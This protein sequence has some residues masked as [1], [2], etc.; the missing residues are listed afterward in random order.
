MMQAGAPMVHGYEVLDVL[1]Q[2]GFGIVYRARQ[3]A[4]G[5]QVALKVDNRVL[6]SERDQRR[7]MREVTAA[8]ALSGHPNVAD[9]YDAGMLSDG[10]P[11]MVLELCPGGSLADR[12]RKERTLPPGEV[13]DI[14]VKIADALA[15]AHAAGVLHRDVKPA[16]ILI[17]SYGMVALSDF[18]LA[19]MP[20]GG[21]AQGGEVSVTR[22][23]L[24]PAY[25]P[26]EAFDLSEPT[27]AGDVY[28]LA[29]TLYAL[30]SGRPPRFPE[31]GVVHIAAIM[32]L[33]RQPIPDIPGVPPALTE[34]LRRAMATDPAARTPSAA[35]LRD[36]LAALPPAAFSA[37][38]PLA[39]PHGGPVHGGPV[40]SGPVHSGPVHSGPVHSGAQPDRRW[41]ATSPGASPAFAGTQPSTG[42]P[43][44]PS[45]GLPHG[46]LN[47]PPNAPSTGQPNG[48][49]TRLPNGYVPPSRQ[50]TLPP[51]P[52]PK[53]GPAVVYA[54]I[55]AVFALLLAGGVT[56]LVID[57]GTDGGS[58]SGRTADPSPSTERASAQPEVTRP[59]KPQL[60]GLNVAT[61]TQGCPAAAVQGAGAACLKEPECWGG[62]VSIAGDVTVKRYGCE[63]SHVWETFAVAPLPVDAQTSDDGALEKHPTI[64]RV[65]SLSVLLKSRYGAARSVTA[66]RWDVTVLP[67]SPEQFAQGV[68]VYRCV[69]SITGRQS[70]GTYFTQ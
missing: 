38:P 7:F 37:V 18:G 49:S 8:G 59:T 54:A 13:R 16:N 53:R 34:V 64:K 21:P 56:L 58:G 55:A 15:A 36:A 9:V 43:H 41:A 11:Y 28:A 5:R 26:P 62:I 61:Y 32:A 63:E 33:H 52:P 57:R 35:A 4:V 10:R 44:G 19:T 17:N 60:P 30:L 3:L 6:V 27:A 1:G 68:R 66:D 50:V 20:G 14:G 48:A 29:A 24:T 46:P 65:C 51:A 69:G 39:M 22:E 25:A 12:Q 42:L 2:G 67:P 47:G 23:S 40:H 70:P 31:G 45:S